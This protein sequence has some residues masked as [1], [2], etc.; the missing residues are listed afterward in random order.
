MNAE[1]FWVTGQT[2]PGLRAPGRIDHLV[3]GRNEPVIQHFHN[4]FRAA[5]QPEAVR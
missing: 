2:I 5:V 1:D 4:C 3:F